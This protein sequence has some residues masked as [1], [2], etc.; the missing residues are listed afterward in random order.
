MSFELD[1]RHDAL[2]EKNPNRSTKPT[3]VNIHMAEM[4]RAIR[5]ADAPFKAGEAFEGEGKFDNSLGRVISQA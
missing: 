3:D 5:E 4:G 1:D 2:T